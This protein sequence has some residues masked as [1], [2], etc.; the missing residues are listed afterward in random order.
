MGKRPRPAPQGMGKN[1]N[2]DENRLVRNYI[3]SYSM[4]LRS[5]FE[6]SPNNMTPTFD[7]KKF[8]TY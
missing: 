3:Y 1:P 5:S 6:F 8:K 2:R 4:R 7:K